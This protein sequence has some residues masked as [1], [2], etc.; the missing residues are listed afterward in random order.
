VS[1]T[2]TTTEAGVAGSAMV[3]GSTAWRLQWLRAVALYLVSIAVALGLS[4][5]LVQLTGNSASSAFTA[6]YQ[7]S[8]QD[9]SSLAI[10]LDEATPLL[11]VALGTIIC[12]KAGIFNIGQEGQLIFGAMIGTA[13][14][15]KMPGPGWLA[16][17]V[18][19]LAAAAGGAFWAGIAALLRY[20]RR[21]DV[22]I[23]TLLLTFIAFQV[24]TYAVTTPWLLRESSLNGEITVPESNMLGDN[25]RLTRIGDELGFNVSVGFF[26]AVLL[27]VV[28]VLVIN[29][30][31]WGFKLRLLGL[32]RVVA[33][34][35]GVSEVRTGGAALLLSGAFAGLAGGVM[36][37]NT[38]F[39]VQ[40]GFSNNVGYEGLLV[41]LVAQGRALVAIPVAFFFG[42]L[43]SGGGFLATTGVPRYLVDV[44]QALLV[45]AAVFPPAFFALRAMRRKTVVAD[46]ASAEAA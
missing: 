4:A 34:R 44:V 23:S 15:L 27:A 22:V 32:N 46:Q 37:T 9:G 6:M 39:R 3:A 40:A 41:A 14:G 18:T 7:G 28:V 29:R 20:W 42:A 25:V 2:T 31:R 35:S 19:L 33:H 38:V 5:A 16:L 13:V 11:I 30:T 21:I 36:L 12:T 8:L 24:V 45:L 10:T 17:S 43:R 26:M 1:V